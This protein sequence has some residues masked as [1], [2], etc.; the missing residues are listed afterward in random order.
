MVLRISRSNNLWGNVR[1]ERKIPL[2]FQIYTCIFLSMLLRLDLTATATAMSVSS[3]DVDEDPGRS[4]DQTSNPRHHHPHNLKIVKAHESP[5]EDQED[6]DVSLPQM[7]AAGLLLKQYKDMAGEDQ[8]SNERTKYPRAL[9]S[10]DFG[11]QAS[12]LCGTSASLKCGKRI[13]TII[14]GHEGELSVHMKCD[15]R[16]DFLKCI[17]T[18]KKGCLELAESSILPELP[19]K[20]AMKVEQSK[21]WKVLW[22][23]GGCVLA[24]Y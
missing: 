16:D 3:V 10:E 14:E 8:R 22:T 9:W 20:E 12:E 5:R 4:S 11:R 19:P 23:A 17:D 1:T 21:L 18:E 7:E 24:N 6:I 15:L 2:L 13:L